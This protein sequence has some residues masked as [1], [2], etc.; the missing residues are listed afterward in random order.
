MATEKTKNP[1]GWLGLACLQPVYSFRVDDGP[2]RECSRLMPRRGFTLLELLVVIAVVGVLAAL[3]LPALSAAKER[4]RQVQC[5]GNLKQIALATLLYAQD[6]E[7]TFPWQPEDGLLVEALGGHGTNYYDFLIPYLGN[8]R[9]WLCASTRDSPG[10]LMS[11]HMNGLLITT[12]GLKSV[13]VRQPSDT[14]LIGESGQGTRWNEAH[15]R[16]DQ[17]G[18]PPYDRPQ[19]HHSGGCNAA[20]VDGHVRWYHDS[21]WTSNYFTPYP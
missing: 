16:P 20:F 15:L 2:P 18:H 17:T 4:G 21:H 5:A 19:K 8:P 14:L 12:N 11:Y 10:R 7:D 13:S 3:M 9:V 1:Q 6:H